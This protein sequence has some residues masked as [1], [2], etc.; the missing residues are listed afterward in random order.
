MTEW[1]ASE[2]GIE[3]S[4]KKWVF[5]G[6]LGL[7]SLSLA[8]AAPPAVHPATGEPLVIECLWGTP[9]AI[10]GDL[11]DWNLAAMTPAVLDA[12]AQVHTGQTSWS[13]PEDCSGVFYLLWD[14]EKIYMA[15]VVK[16]D[17]LSMNKTNGDIWNADCIEIF[18][19]TTNAVSEHDEHYQYGFNAN[20]QTWNWC[21]MDS[22]G[23]SAIDYLQVASTRT[24][25]GYICEASIDY[26]QMASLDF[27]VGNAIGFHPVIDDT[28]NGDRE[29]QMTW[30]SREAHDQTLGY[31]HLILSAEPAIAK[32]L[33]RNPNPAND[34]ADVPTDVILSWDPGAFAASHD[35]YFGTTFDDV[36]DATRGDPRGVLVSQGQT[37]AS[38][39]PPGVLDYGQ[40]YYWRIDE[41]N[42]PPNSTIFKGQIWWFAAEP[43]GYPIESIIAT[44]N[45]DSDEGAGPEKTI[46]GSGLDDADRHSAAATDMWLA[47]APD[48]EPLYIQYEFDRVYELHEMLVWNY[49]VQFE[50][51]LGFGLKDVTVQYSV[52]AEG[53]TVLRDVEFARGASMA[54]YAANTVVDL[55]GVSARYVRLIVNSGWST[56]G[57]FGLSEVRFLF[58]PVQARQPQPADGATEVD[59][60]TLLSWRAGRDA[61]SHQ[62]YLGTDPEELTLV[63]DAA[64][65]T[66]APDALYFGD[67]YYWRIDAVGDGVWAGELWSFATKSYALI[68]GFETYNDD[69]DAG[70]TI[71]DTWLDGWVNNTGSTVGYL[72]APFAEET[73]V[74]SGGQSMPLQYDNTDSPFYSE[75]E[76]VFASPQN[77]SG[78]GADTLVLYVRGNAPSFE[79]TSGGRIIMSAVGTDIW[80]TADQFRY[81]YKSLSGN[82][83]ITVRIDSV[84][85]SNEWAKAG[86]M[87]RETLEAGSKHAFVALTPEPT[88]G[89]S[90]QRRPVAGT[91]SAN[92]D[93]ADISLPYWAKLTRTNNLFTAQISADGV[94]WVDITPT[95]PV[96]ISMTA[97][98]YIGLAVTS[99]DATITTAAEFS[100]LAMTGSVTGA[101]QTAEIGATQPVGNSAD[102]MY[103]R[104]E[105][106]TGKSVT[107]VSADEAI[108]LHS[109]WQEWAISYADLAGV[110]LSRIQTMV[111]GVGNR[112]S[113]SAGGT[114][115]VYIDDVGFGRPA[116]E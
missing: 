41:V 61:T 26:R 9:D 72:N 100:N 92:T 27:S 30:T 111:I 39:D 89:A 112:T 77:W 86:V 25:D 113:P 99:H 71:F 6:I 98:V 62:L 36:N 5:A 114:G 57:Q 54:G 18:F 87:I 102:P 31:G 4:A 47:Y 58:I 69:I 88:H 85:R 109:T 55:G 70:T 115:T 103:V 20:E 10:D 68:D 82:G 81:A 50:M 33:S 24:A 23:Q 59:P 65:T 21:N 95:A 80:G 66:Y 93:V 3:M 13:D 1:I 104:I 28:D 48:E 38:Y 107:V 7:L 2:G 78:H 51:I 94:T 15:V 60:A 46:D 79:E 83:S 96:E 97:N 12:A 49:N 22:D 16:D 106:S 84:I 116:V 8:I 110:N 17:K 11:S 44:T 32:E 64:Q 40:T 105:D 53:W 91:D 74:R 67:S 19:A 29:I 45:G 75:A 35:V 63:A 52:D 90:F 42:A 43:V 101:W 76:R 108:T 56:L 34:A 37:A 73:I 14:D